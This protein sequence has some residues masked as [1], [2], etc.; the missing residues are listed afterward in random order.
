MSPALT[1]AA[2]LR[3]A[4]MHATTFREPM[5]PGIIAQQLHKGTE[6]PRT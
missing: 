5:Q 2:P 1:L 4:A 6:G 3:T